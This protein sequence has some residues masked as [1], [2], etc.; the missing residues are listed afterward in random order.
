[1][2]STT[3]EWTDLVSKHQ[4]LLKLQKEKQS[5]GICWKI[6]ARRIVLPKWSNLKLIKS[7]DPS[8]NLQEIHRTYWTRLWVI[9][10]QNQHCGQYYGLKNPGSWTNTLEKGKNG[11]EPID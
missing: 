9:D 5:Y 1:M 4:E 6:T 7:L 8:A 10:Q 2:Q 11:R 3:N